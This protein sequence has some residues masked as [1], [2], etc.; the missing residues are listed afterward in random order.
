MGGPDRFTELHGT[1]R[2]FP[3]PSGPVPGNSPRPP[4]SPSGEDLT[5]M[6]Q[7]A[8]AT[9]RD[10]KTFDTGGGVTV[11]RRSNRK[12]WLLVIL[13][14]LGILLALGLTKFAQFTKMFA[15]GKAT[16]PPPE[17]VA[18]AK[19]QSLDW[20]PTRSGVGTL[21][22]LRGVTL[23]AEVTGTVREIGFENGGLVKKGQLIVRLDTSAESAQLQSAIADAALAKQT[24]ERAESLR[25]QE[26]NTQ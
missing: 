4:S 13:V 5:F 12:L 21:V 6:F 26:V 9:T 1:V 2:R 22:A 25:K 15:V 10:E 18:S 24:L 20:Q 16:V 11:T 23:S 3:E 8:Q 7:P 19:V 14:L 17:S